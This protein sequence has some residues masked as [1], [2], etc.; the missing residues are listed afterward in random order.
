[1]L[2]SLAGLAFVL[3]GS[4][5]GAQVSVSA[6]PPRDVAPGSLQAVVFTVSNGSAAPLDLSFEASV[7]AGVGVLVPPQDVTLGAGEVTLVPV[8]VALDAN[9]A[10]GDYAVTLTPRGPGAGSPASAVL[11]VSATPGLALTGPDS[12]G[13]GRLS[14][15]V[16]NRG[17]VPDSVTV[18]A[19]ASADVRV[20]PAAL[21]AFRLAA[22]E[23][24]E[25]VFDLTAGRPGSLTVTAVG[26]SGARAGLLARVLPDATLEP[27]PFY[28]HGVLGAS[29]P[30]PW[31]VSLSALGPLSDF[32]TLGVQAGWSGDGPRASATVTAGAFSVQAG[33]LSG[34]AA[35]TGVPYSGW[36]GAF[37]AN[38]G[39]WAFSLAG[40]TDGLAGSGSYSTS[41]FR[42][43]LGGGW[44][45]GR[46]S[47]VL[48]ASLNGNP[49]GSL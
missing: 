1:M 34:S 21:P 32:A 41:A 37:T 11:S 17:N 16:V 42:V 24:R 48:A 22:G 47:V 35:V 18:E 30:S 9:L 3:F 12:V 7:P 31:S 49:N 46:E 13:P 26:S 8:T 14:L 5:A 38:P 4:V 19:S 44:I 2:A 40:S 28:L 20:M 27:P 10:A 15:T 25:L 39:P 33:F 45:L 43:G 29:G 6:Q 23:S 36:G